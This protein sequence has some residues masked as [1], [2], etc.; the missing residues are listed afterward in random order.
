M[1]EEETAQF[2]P[3]STTADNSDGTEEAS[4][5]HHKLFKATIWLIVLGTVVVL[6]NVLDIEETSATLSNLLQESPKPEGKSKKRYYYTPSKKNSSNAT[7]QSTTPESISE[8]PPPAPEVPAAAETT[9]ATPNP[10]HPPA[11]P[12]PTEPVPP[13]PAPADECSKLPAPTDGTCAAAN[14]STLDE[15]V[16]HQELYAGWYSLNNDG[17]CQDFCRWVGSSGSGGDPSMA[18]KHKKSYWSC[19]PAGYTACTYFE[20]FG[21]SFNFVKCKRQGV[22]AASKPKQT[23]EPVPPPPAPEPVVPAPAPEP[24]P[25]PGPPGLTG[26]CSKLPAPTDDTCAAANPSTLDE[27]V[28]H[29]ELYAGWYSLNNDGCCQDF[30]RWVGS[31]GSGGDP[32]MGT[33]HKKSYWSCRPAGYTACTYFEGFG[34]SFNF[35]KCK[36][37]GVPA[38]SNPEQKAEPVPPPPAPEPV[39]PAPAPEPVQGPAVPAGECSKLPAPTDGTCA[40]ANPST[41]DPGVHNQ[42]A[43][44]GWYSLNNDGCCQD[45]CRWVGNGGQ[46]GDPRIKV[47]HGDAFWSCRPAGY[48]ACPYFQGFGGTFNFAKCVSQGLAAPPGVDLSVPR[49]WIHVLNWSE[50]MA[51]WRLSVE[52]VLTAA[53]AMNGTFVEPCVNSGRLQSCAVFPG[54]PGARLG[55]LVN[56]EELKKFHPY[57]VSWEEFVAATGYDNSH[58][59]SPHYFHACFEKYPCTD[60]DSEVPPTFRQYTVKVMEDAAKAGQQGTS[61]LEIA[62]YRKQALVRFQYRGRPLKDIIPNTQ[63]LISRA[64]FP[65]S[66]YQRVEEMLEKLNI[67]KGSRWA[68]IQWRPEIAGLDYIKCAESILWAR[69]HIS[70]RD[71]IPE[72]NFILMS[73]LSNM[74]GLQWGG[75]KHMAEA[76]Q[77]TSYPSLNMLLDAGFKK[78]EQTF[79][80]DLPDGGLLAIYD[81]ILGQTATS[82]TTCSG[83]SAASYCSQCNYQGAASQFV[84]DIRGQYQK[85]NEGT[86][87]CWPHGV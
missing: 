9:P 71:N 23:A 59:Q 83:C 69:D 46:G 22:P 25:V 72:T 2:L 41:V 56:L 16:R 84:L 40:A 62:S 61:I 55:H 14:P 66:A 6:A 24:V 78:L 11:T 82:F 15:G 10:T 80:A 51:A 74:K 33:K 85:A 26:E 87:S 17:C 65:P 30:C 34:D 47:T 48:T 13:P 19:R 28:R 64:G 29:Q 7:L 42:D 52:E 54:T 4:T 18:I 38:A 20:G 39:V 1:S 73:P 63:G 27:G 21:D 68:A 76:N 44:A 49:L 58:R 37:Q 57:I 70:H 35:V 31:S 53:K 67:P 36:R 77:E 12:Q 86:E 79:G 8:P 50:G 75:V 81:F 32:S 3:T 5:A 43:I 60:G 45:Y